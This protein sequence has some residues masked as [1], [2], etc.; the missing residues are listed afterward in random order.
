MG[1]WE[2][3]PYELHAWLR[4]ATKG[5]ATR[6]KE[7]IRLEIE[8]HYAEAVSDHLKKGLSECDARSAA[9]AE[10]GNARK[11]AKCFRERHLTAREAVGVE[12]AFSRQG[13]RWWLLSNYI[14]CA[15]LF[16]A[17]KTHYRTLLVPLAVVFIATVIIPTFN[18]VTIRRMVR[19]KTKNVCSCILR[20]IAAWY[21]FAL[22]VLL[23]CFYFAYGL[24]SRLSATSGGHAVTGHGTPFQSHLPDFSFLLAIS[25]PLIC[26]ISL[27][28]CFIPAL[29]RLLRLR[30]VANVWDELPLR[31]E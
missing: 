24:Q 31:N 21:A 27:I 9:I 19:R 28:I 6:A 13:S 5:L 12:W 4:I 14:Y 29:R 18:Y 23:L 25:G 11:A 2:R 10:L 8:A 3:Q 1:I 26:L 17:V 22:S 7:R 16:F 15:C 30:R 20:E